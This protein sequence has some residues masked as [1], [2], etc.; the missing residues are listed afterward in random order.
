MLL[1]VSLPGTHWFHLFLTDFYILK[2]TYCFHSLVVSFVDRLNRHVLYWFLQRV[3]YSVASLQFV[4]TRPKPFLHIILNFLYDFFQ[5]LFVFFSFQ[6]SFRHI[7]VGSRVFYF[8]TGIL[9]WDFLNIWLF[10]MIFFYQNFPIILF[11]VRKSHFEQKID[12]AHAGNINEI[13]AG[14]IN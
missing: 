6:Y 7:A 8:P 5:I 4:W 11:F 14:E 13:L 10:L 12:T 2:R 3:C 1:V 9:C